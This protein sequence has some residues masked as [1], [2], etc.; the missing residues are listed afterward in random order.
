VL[1]S[2]ENYTLDTGRRELR[3]D[4]G[5]IPVEPQVFDILEYL[6]R[7]RDRVVSRDDLIA[8]VWNGRVV[9]E[10]AL[11]TRINAVRTAIG[12]SGA[13]QRLIKTFPR[14][15]L[16]FLGAVREDRK[17]NDHPSV[18]A[19]PF[20]GAP[21]GDAIVAEKRH[22][23]L[24]NKPS[25]AVLP[26][27]NLSPDPEQ[28]YFADGIANDIIT[29]L[30]SYPSL[31]VIARNSSFSYK[32][33]DVN[34][35]RIGHE[36]GVR[37]V[38][39][40]SVRKADARV[41]VTSQLIETESG[42]HMWANRYDADVTNIFAVQ[43]EITHAVS[44]AIA[45][46][47]ADAERHRAVRRSPDS[48]DSW[49]AYQRGLWHLSRTTPQDNK[50][51]QQC[52][53]EAIAIDPNFSGGY[54]GLA[55]AQ[56]QESGLFATLSVAQARVSI[57]ALALRAVA[58]DQSDADAHA[59]LSWA[60]NFDGDYDGALAEARRALTIS[61]NLASAH[62]ALGTTLTF[63]GEPKQGLV[64]LQTSIRLDPRDP[65]LPWHL[66]RVAIAQYFSRDYEAAVDTARRV[67]RL[68]PNFPLIYRWLAAALGQLGR[69]EE[70]HDAL[71]QAI[72][73]ARGS[74]DMYVRERVPWHRVEDYEHMLDGLRKAG[75]QG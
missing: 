51:A 65:L 4:S 16:R 38:L 18:A 49:S 45:P 26:F 31:L 23:P 42:T 56:M 39:E 71:D 17:S 5:L 61:P 15:G 54:S 30:S 13:A 50:A 14:K 47:V 59:C 6:L 55:L 32:G 40:G 8:S 25:I 19:R 34:V 29:A 21:R 10:S 48:H 63:A 9:S 53:A 44:T 67:I 75:W 62:R 37:Y 72:A 46:A 41:R 58:N 60:L 2:F 12:D 43:D 28:E 35:Q 66:N 57:K 70:A 20:D 64:A 68:H 3:R 52:F 33:I 27:A 36:L 24:P 22:L 73:I 7:N 11:S 1:Y 69:V 74:F